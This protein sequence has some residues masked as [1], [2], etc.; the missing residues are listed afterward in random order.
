M[1]Q[2]KKAVKKYKAIMYR[3]GKIRNVEGPFLSKS[4]GYTYLSKLSHWNNVDDY[5]LEWETV[6]VGDT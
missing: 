1:T 6:I 2:R 3:D 4:E 5:V